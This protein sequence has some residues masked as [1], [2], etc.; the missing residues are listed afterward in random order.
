MLQGLVIGFFLLVLVFFITAFGGEMSDG[1][2]RYRLGIIVSA[3]IGKMRL[4][5]QSRG[6]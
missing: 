2:L 5:L 1:S 4:P 3:I 6:T